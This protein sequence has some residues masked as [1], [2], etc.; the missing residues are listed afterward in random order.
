MQLNREN[1]LVLITE[2]IIFALFYLIQVGTLFY[3]LYLG[4]LPLLF[5]LIGYYV[6]DVRSVIARTLLHKDSIIFYTAL[7]IWLFLLAATHN[8]PL[9]VFETAYYPVFLEEFNFRFILIQFLRRR[10][11]LGRSVVIQSAMYA[12]FYASFLIFYPSGYPGIFTELF[13]LDNFSMAL[14]YGAIYY[15]RKNFYIPATLHLSFYLIDIF[16]PASLGW[17]PYVTTPV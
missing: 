1:L 12:A 9:Y 8:G 3:Y 4:V 17:L 2:P 11:S 13:I 10:F 5:I 14:V 15:F 6:K 7:M 16:L